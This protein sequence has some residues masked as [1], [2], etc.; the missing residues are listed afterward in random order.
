MKNSL[1]KNPGSGKRPKLWRLNWLNL[2]FI[3]IKVETMTLHSPETNIFCTWKWIGGIRSFP[4]GGGAEL[5]VSR[6]WR[7]LGGT[8]LYKT[9]MIILAF[10]LR[11][12]LY[13]FPRSFSSATYNGT[14][15]R[16]PNTFKMYFVLK[17]F[18]LL[19]PFDSS[20]IEVT[21]SPLKRSLGGVWFSWKSRDSFFPLDEY[22]WRS[23]GFFV[24]RK[25]PWLFSEHLGSPR[26]LNDKFLQVV[27]NQVFGQIITTSP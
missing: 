25:K 10:F 22:G 21:I 16:S 1:A 26:T 12:I 24:H 18:F 15:T 9:S 13:L 11:G 7:A 4:F 23:A 3:L 8:H 14:S 27:L 19:C 6:E 17:N 5:L 2:P 20:K